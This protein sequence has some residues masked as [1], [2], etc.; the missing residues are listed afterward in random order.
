MTAPAAT[1]E[2]TL[3]VI[4]VDDDET[5]RKVISAVLSQDPVINVCGEAA[6]GGDAVAL[7]YEKRPDVAIVDVMMPAGG[8]PV[9]TRGIARFSPGTAVLALSAHDDRDNVLEMLRAGAVGYLVKGSAHEEIIASVRRAARGEHS[10]SGVVLDRVVAEL[11][12]KLA[13][14]ESHDLRV[15]EEL[16]RVHAIV[17]G[18]LIQM[19]FQPIVDLND[20]TTVAYEALARFP[21][22]P[23]RSPDAW[24]AA[25]ASVGAQED[26]ELA[27][28]GAALGCFD[29]VDRRLDI[30]IN[31]SPGT[32][33]SPRF[34]EMLAGVPLDRVLIEITEHAPVD[35]YDALAAALAPL[36]RRGLR[37][38]VDDA[39]AGFASLRHILRLS[40][41]VV[42]VDMSLIRGI[43][44]H[45]G[46][47]A[48]TRALIS[49]ADETGA[50]LIAE[51]IETEEELEVL[52]ALGAN[53]GQ[54]YLLGRP[55]LLSAR[56]GNALFG[57]GLRR[58]A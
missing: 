21:L 5:V 56:D 10:L 50:Q 28:V 58:S 18:G 2:R 1:R 54:G 35:D 8:G 17:E 23:V 38:A 12:E 29:A 33:A 45:P 31:I 6:S 16:A 51:G 9:A 25:A 49:F 43:E 15:R 57:F 55:S 27:A 52:R 40:P 19:V 48:V 37:V 13:A 41:D 34:V 44:R 11:N 47:R 22:E 46:Q 4:V 20:R 7:A 26:L 14:E 32:A 39:G 42:K 30:G 3:D 24:F 36:R 53:I